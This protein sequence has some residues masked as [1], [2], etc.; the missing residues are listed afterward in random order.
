LSSGNEAILKAIPDPTDEDLEGGDPGHE[1]QATRFKKLEAELDAETL[2]LRKAAEGQ[3]AGEPTAQPE[4]QPAVA[5]PATQPTA[6]VVPEWAN[7]AEAEAALPGLPEAVRPF[8]AALVSAAHNDVTEARTA[9]RPVIE[10]FDGIVQ[11]LEANGFTDVAPLVDSYR[12][13]VATHE[14]IMSVYAPIV[15]M[16]V[17]ARMPVLKTLPAEVRTALAEA[18]QAGAHETMK[19]DNDVERIEELAKYILYKHNIP[20]T[21]DA[22]IARPAPAP[23]PAAP[24]APQ[25][26]PT[27]PAPSP[28]ATHAARAAAI[29]TGNFGSPTRPTPAPKTPQEIEDAFD[30]ALG[31]TLDDILGKDRDTSWSRT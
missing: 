27:G 30:Y 14:Q 18:I 13:A 12:E 20:V 9:L 28:S 7:L 29:S 16:A 17:E 19:G 11:K 15:Q 1:E 8:A 26:K 4:G 25:A 5:Q 22:P 2:E 23:A 6:P 24:A 10:R 31:D 3:P 21:G